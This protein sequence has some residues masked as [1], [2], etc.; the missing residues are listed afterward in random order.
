MAGKGSH[1]MEMFNKE[2]TWKKFISDGEKYL[3]TAVN[4]H[5]KRENIFTPDLIYHII[6]M[7]IEN[8][9]MGYLFY[10]DRLPDNHTLVDLINAVKEICEV[11]EDLYQRILSMN[12]FQEA[13]CSLSAQITV[14]P[15]KKDIQEFLFLGESIRE[16]VTGQLPGPSHIQTPAR[17]SRNDCHV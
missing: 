8:Y 11:D 4:G 3:K 10:N 2:D 6:C 7:S 12:R 16:F 17:L 1:V 5:K 9:I 15:K 13:V 14:V